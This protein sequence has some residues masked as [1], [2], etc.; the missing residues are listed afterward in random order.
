MTVIKIQNE[1]NILIYELE[2]ENQVRP[3][4]KD[5]LWLINIFDIKSVWIKKNKIGHGILG[6]T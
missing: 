3:F 6:V 2:N 1:F 4:A 5:L